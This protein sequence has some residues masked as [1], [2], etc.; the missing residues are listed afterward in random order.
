MAYQLELDESLHDGVRRIGMEQIDRSSRNLASSCSPHEAIHD[1]RKNIK[2]IRSLLCLIRPGLSEKIYRRE[3]RKF[4]ALSKSL[5]GARDTHVMLETLTYLENLDG[6]RPKAKLSKKIRTLLNKRQVAIQRA[7]KSGKKDN[8]LARLETAQQKF[9][10]L[11]LM[12]NN[13]IIITRGINLS[14][15]QGRKMIKTTYHSNKSAHFHE[16]RKIVQRH[17]RHMQLL[18]LIWPEMC[19]ARANCAKEL[20]EILGYHNDINI[21]A[22]FV[23]K[24][25]P[26]HVK[27]KDITAFLKICKKQKNQLRLEAR[28]Y[29][30]RL[31]TEKPKHFSKRMT[32]YWQSARK[33]ETIIF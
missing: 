16:W 10:R 24:K 11:P 2:K 21:L 31:F 7:L 23:A 32:S 15:A 29:G 18:S 14:Y 13:L 12:R 22:A 26:E 5:S 30:E 33:I 19:E 9:R 17:W 4:K 27:K 25:M 8:T 1:V 20:S 3:N 28:P 6:P